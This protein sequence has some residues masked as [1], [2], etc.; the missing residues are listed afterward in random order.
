MILYQGGLEYAWLK[1]SVLS[2]VF[3][4]VFGRAFSVKKLPDNLVI[5]N[6]SSMINDNRSA[7][8]IIP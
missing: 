6:G 7:L 4:V 2:R 1:L 8:M 3:Q 5:E